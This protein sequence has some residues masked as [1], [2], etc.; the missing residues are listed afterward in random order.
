[1]KK[2]YF[3]VFIALLCS[4]M[5]IAQETQKNYINYQGVARDAERQLMANESMT[6][7]I[8]IKIGNALA[9]PAYSENHLITT[10]ANGVFSLKI[11]NGDATSGDYGDIPWG[12]DAAFVT[13]SIEGSEIGTTEMMAVPY[14][15][16]SGDAKQT[17]DQVPYNLSLIHI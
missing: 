2:N 8:A 15:L 9:A 11:G 12:G 6:L 13:V 5:V 17:A 16:S 7:G 10:D 14:A 1:M 4:G 3:L